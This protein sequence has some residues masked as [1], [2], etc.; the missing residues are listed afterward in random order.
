MPSP[1]PQVLILGARGRL[2]QAA[3]YA[4]AQ[5]GWQVRAQSRRPLGHYPQNAQPW[6][7]DATDQAAL[8]RAAQGV[9]VILNALNPLY[10]RWQ[11]DALLLAANALAAAR[12]SGAMLLVAGN[13]YNFGAMLPPA[14]NATTPWVG[15]TAKARIRMAIEQDLAAAA[16]DGVAS[17]VLRAGDYFGGSGRGSWFD[18]VIVASLAKGKLVW[19]G[20]FDLAHAWAYVPDLAH[21]FVRLAEQ[22]HQLG[23][24][25]SFVF[26]G[27]TFTGTELYGVI[28]RMLP[29][30]LRLQQ[31]SWSMVRLLGLVSPMMRATLAMRYLWQ[32]PHQLE[33]DVALRQLLGIVPHTALPVAVSAALRELQL[34]PGAG[35][36]RPATI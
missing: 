32:R 30:P 28:Q 13:V 18:L 33:E 10:S 34:L 25:R 16:H 14:L 3:V 29:Q 8:C 12:S 22:R 6:L 1:T 23:G 4:F 35:A 26:G 7:C 20:P 9:D 2:G 17:V 27:H 11:Q 31:L 19:P 24:A 5:A 15:N 36:I 21:T